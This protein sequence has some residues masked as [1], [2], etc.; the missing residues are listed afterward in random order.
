MLWIKERRIQMTPLEQAKA[1]RKARV[2]GTR[3]DCSLCPLTEECTGYHCEEKLGWFIYDNEGVNMEPKRG[4]KVLVWDFNS[5]TVQLI[6]LAN[7]GGSY[8]IITVS[9]ETEHLYPDGEYDSLR[10]K[11]M[12]I[13]P[14]IK[15]M[16]VAEVSE[17]LGYEVKIVKES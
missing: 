5:Q 10:W 15:E 2:D 7:V 14:A 4:D 12:K 9:L 8:P 17:A 13:L 16:T 11:H 1:C 3:I 6:F